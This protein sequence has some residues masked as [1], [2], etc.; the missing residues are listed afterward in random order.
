MAFLKIDNVRIAGVSAAVPTKKKDIRSLPFFAP[1]EAEKVIALT[2]VEESRIAPQGICCSDLCYTAAERLISSMHWDK[3]EIDALIFVSLSRDYI[4]PAT[5]NILQERLGLSTECLAFDIPL[6]CSGYVYGLSVIA[7]LMSTGGIR[8]AL[9]LVGE[10]TSR[11]QSPHDK[12]LWPIHGDA[13]TATAIEY[14]TQAEPMFFHL[15]S[16]GSRASAIMNQYGGVRFPMTEEGLEIKEREPGPVMRNGLHAYMDGLGVFSFSIKEPPTCI[17]NLCEHFDI[18]LDDIDYLLLHQA[19]KYMDDK[20]GRKLKV[21]DSKIPFSLMK[22]G[23]TSSASI[24]MTIV[25]ALG[26]SI[27]KQD[28]HAI[29]CGFGAGLSWAA[30]QIQLNHITCLPLIEV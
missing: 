1:G 3:S 27:T 29:I 11:M 4:A 18:S 26:E 20:I 28:A 8:K 15:C 24:P 21:P 9:L 30:A 12:T 19:N 13:G 14:D 7:S 2:H 22:F 5:A 6:A 17:T 16:D 25:V 23:N 10:T